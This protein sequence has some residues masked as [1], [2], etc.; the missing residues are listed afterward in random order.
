MFV[1][2]NDDQRYHAAVEI[3][4]VNF[5]GLLDSGA[6]VTVAGPRFQSMLAEGKIVSR[7]S[8]YT[9]R[10]ADGTLHTTVDALSLPIS[11]CGVTHTIEAPLL[12]SLKRDL[13]LG[14]DFWQKFNIKPAVVDVGSIEAEKCVNVS[15]N[16]ELSEYEA[17]RLNEVLKKMPFCKPGTLSKTSLTK[18]VINTGDA[19]PIK[20]TQYIISPYVQK[21]VHAEIDRLLSIGAIFPCS[22][23]WNNKVIAVHKPTGKIRLCIDARKL[24]ALT[25]KDAYPQPQLNRILGQLSGTQIL[26]SIDFS[27]AYHQVELD[28]DSKLKT[29]FSVSG[30]GFFAY[31]RMP[32]GLC[33][34]GA[35]LCR[36]VDQVLG[37]DL[38]PHVFVYMDDVIIA[39]QTIEHH[40]QL[41]AVIAKRLSDAGLTISPE[42]SRFCMKRLKYLGH[43]SVAH[44]FHHRLPHPQLREGCTPT[45]RYG[46]V[47]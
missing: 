44:I 42:K 32:F 34:S 43:I 28:E 39:T 15:E 5:V 4:G 25:I 46:R 35:T 2:V 30:K 38:E 31:A 12:P 10:T 11:Y 18:H 33:N 8:A 21:D 1:T 14:I 16:M 37:C 7:P 13:V 17:S 45:T 22:S 6:E 26:S 3:S 27:D 20:Q 9:I 24:N 47:V 36:L 40:L 41:L 19:R 23:P 29:A